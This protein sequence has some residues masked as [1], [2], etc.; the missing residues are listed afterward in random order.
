M[1]GVFGLFAV[2]SINGA[3]AQSEGPAHLSLVAGYKAA[4][5]CSALYNAGR[6]VEAIADD[7]LHRIYSGYRDTMA[8]LP[9]AQY[10]TQ[11]IKRG[12]RRNAFETTVK[13]VSVAYADNAPPRYAV[14]RPGLGCVQ[15]PTYADLSDIDSIPL[16]RLDDVRL[17]AQ[18]PWPNGDAISEPIFSQTQDGSVLRDIVTSAFDRLTYGEGT[19]TT[20]VLVVK[21]GEIIAERYREGFTKTTPQRTWSV[22]KSI[23]ASIIGAAVDEGVIKTD[24]P[25][26]IDA[27]SAAGDP[28]GDI[29]LEDLLHM[30]SGLTSLTAGNRTDDVYFGGGR[31]IDHAITN[32]LVA[33]PGTRWRYANNDTMIAMRALRE[34]MG[35][36]NEFLHFPFEELLHPIGMR[37]TFLET[38]WNGDFILSSQVWTTARDLARLGLLY[39]NDGVWDGRRI[40]PEDWNDY[41][42]TPSPDQPP[43]R[44]PGIAPPG[45]GAQWW[46]YGEA[47]ALPNGSYAAR[48]NRGQCLMIVPSR[49]VLIIRRGFDDG[50]GF[51]LARFSADILMA[52]P[53]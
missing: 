21:N 32:R 23:A 39:L 52:I 8:Q 18:M 11:T 3:N 45:Y 37:H 31:V 16:V 51:D 28:R 47:H 14:W 9:D 27:W 7:E 4:F 29:T 53:E 43:V 10:E 13:I 25:A 38:D 50:G 44:R 2:G 24:T 5:T 1:M 48:G 17:T 34:R 20:A 6:D 22:A 30:S 41:V 33:E 40:L 19:E 35:D 36:D 26:G 12:K 49:D 46:L 42:A 15:L